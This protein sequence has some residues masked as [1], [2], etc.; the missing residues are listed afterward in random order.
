MDELKDKSVQHCMK[1][2]RHLRAR[3]ILSTQHLI[4]VAKSA[5]EQVFLIILLKGISEDYIR[6]LPGRIAAEISP[7]QLQAMYESATEEDRHFL[8]I[9]PRERE[10]RFRYDFFPRSINV[11]ELLRI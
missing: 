4:H 3:V 9:Y 11:T 1:L 5:W 6:K 7:D 10:D 2:N 8:S